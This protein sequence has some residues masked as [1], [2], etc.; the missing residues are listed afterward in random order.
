M[1]TSVVRPKSLQPPRRTRRTTLLGA[2]ALVSTMVVVGS[3]SAPFS[4]DAT[5][6][7]AVNLGTAADFGVLAGNAVTAGTA[8]NIVGYAGVYPGTA[9]T[10]PRNTAIATSAQSSQAQT[11]AA[12]AYAY[13]AALTTTEVLNTVELG[14][15]TL[16]PGV[17]STGAAY[18]LTGNLILDGKDNPDAVFV[19]KTPADSALVTAAASTITL[20]GGAQAGNVFWQIS[21][22]VTTGEASAF[23]GTVLAQAA[24]T[25]GADTAVDG[26]LL[27]LS[28]AAAAT[29]GAGTY[30]VDTVAPA[31]AIDGGSAAL[32]NDKTPTITG[33]SEAGATVT[34][35]IDG[36]TVTPTV[37]ADGTWSVTSTTLTDANH[38]VR[39]TATDPA[40][41]TSTPATQTLTVDT[42]AD[43]VAIN[44]GASVSTN[45]V[46]PTISGITSAPAGSAVTVTVDGGS[47][48]TTVRTGETWEVTLPTLAEG[49]YT[50]VA[51]VTDVAGN[52][53]SATQTLTIDTTAPAVTIDGGSAK[54]TN[55]ATPT[56]TGTSEAGSTL[57]VTIDGQNFTPTVANNG[58]WTV[59]STTLADSNHTVR[60]TATDPAG[61]TSTATQTLTV[62]TTAPT[63]TIDG[64]SAALTNDQTPT[65]TG[66]SEAGATVTVTIDGQNF[67]PT[68]ATDGTWTVTSTTLTNG[69]HTVRAT[70]T[71][72]TT[73]ARTTNQSDTATQTLT[74]DTTSRNVTAPT[75]TSVGD[76]DSTVL[77]ALIENLG[78]VRP[79]AAVIL[80]SESAALDAANYP[81]YI[82]RYTAPENRSLISSFWEIGT[83]MAILTALAFFWLIIAKRRR[84]EDEEQEAAADFAELPVA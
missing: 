63:V 22:A 4:A 56:I 67:T 75:V 80:A 48:P 28:A 27:S 84:R 43:T 6:H 59:T 25:T 81:A 7:S 36:Q 68:V 69:N 8:I 72:G 16:G 3:L 18:G 2:A 10:V 35:T 60:A 13:A 20:I 73:N 40:G 41:N 82:T 26:R 24:I 79:L 19:F 51:S 49:V 45:D 31:V 34:V 5:S 77:A 38:A 74:L 47:A 9:I 55:D 61:N 52:V 29:L 65:I 50:V 78:T 58:T 62:D 83:L 33:T 46:T 21:G 30:F 64:G 39:A 15:R 42:V 17:Y 12:A 53:G 14:G 66:T 76:S 1:F 11:D 57:T 71:N 23:V 32:T 70:A 44:G 37:A 54:L